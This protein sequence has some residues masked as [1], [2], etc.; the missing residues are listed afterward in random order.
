MRRA[1]EIETM[2][3]DD[4]DPTDKADFAVFALACY[5]VTNPR[6]LI[7]FLSRYAEHAIPEEDIRKDS[8]AW[9][10]VQRLHDLMDRW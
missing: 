2:N 7:T 5:K 6:T 8:P 10:V 1:A 3:I 4:L 9:A